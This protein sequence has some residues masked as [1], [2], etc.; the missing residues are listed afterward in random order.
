MHIISQLDPN[1][2]VR[3]RQKQAELWD[4]IIGVLSGEWERG[5]SRNWTTVDP[6]LVTDE[7]ME[8]L[9]YGRE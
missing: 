2:Y 7:V 4:R 5:W 9:A 3:V 6:D 1:L 8:D